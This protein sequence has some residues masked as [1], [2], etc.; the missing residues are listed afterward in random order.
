VQTLRLYFRNI[1]SGTPFDANALSLDYSLQ[2]QNGIANWAQAAGPSS[3]P[4]A[5]AAAGAARGRL[6]RSR[7]VNIRP[8]GRDG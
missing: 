5:A 8:V 4:R 6:D 3:A 2:L 7:G 1:K